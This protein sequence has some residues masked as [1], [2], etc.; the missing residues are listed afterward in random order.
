MDEHGRSSYLQFQE[1]S[2]HYSISNVES[3]HFAAA[4]Q[5]VAVNIPLPDVAGGTGVFVG[6]VAT[7]NSF[8]GGRRIFAHINNGGTFGQIV[9]FADAAFTGDVDIAYIIWYDD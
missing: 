8:A 4:S 5:S 6:A 1:N 9:A 2:T 3:V 7:C